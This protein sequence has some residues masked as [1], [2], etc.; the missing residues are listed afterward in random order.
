M[1][2]RV[3]IIEIDF[4]EDA[5]LRPAKSPYSFVFDST[6]MVADVGDCWSCYLG[7]STL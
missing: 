6:T 2:L 7:V 5:P 3:D 1:S 4:S